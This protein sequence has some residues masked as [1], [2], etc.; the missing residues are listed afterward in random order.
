MRLLWKVQGK[1]SNKQVDLPPSDQGGVWAED[2]IFM[3][4]FKNYCN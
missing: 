4:T 3:K 1:M 2:F